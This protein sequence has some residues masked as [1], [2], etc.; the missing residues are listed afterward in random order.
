MKDLITHAPD[1]SLLYAEGVAIAATPEHALFEFFTVDDDKNELTFNVGKTPIHYS[2]MQSLTVVD[3]GVITRDLLD[4][5]TS[6]SVLGEIENGV[7]TFDSDESQA[8]YEAV[9]G[10]LTYTIDGEEYEKPYL[11]GVIAR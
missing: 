11:I 6:I 4:W 3:G 10:E 7:A 9:R 5:S 1:L 2:D 8:T